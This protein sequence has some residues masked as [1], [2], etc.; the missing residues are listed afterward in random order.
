M[1]I[2][3]SNCTLNSLYFSLLQNLLYIFLVYRLIYLN[4]VKTYLYI[5]DPVIETIPYT[6]L[7]FFS[8][9]FILFNNILDLLFSLSLSYSH[10]NTLILLSG[11]SYSSS[12]SFE[13]PL[14]IY[15]LLKF[16]PL[17]IQK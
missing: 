17:F 9:F 1:F 3:I 11:F 15:Y 16:F 4:K 13:K 6:N 7:S 5:N 2:C 14:S 12:S 10:S 8:Y